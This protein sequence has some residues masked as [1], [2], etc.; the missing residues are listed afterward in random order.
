MTLTRLDQFALGYHVPDGLGHYALA[1]R[2]WLRG[3]G[4]ASDLYAERSN[5]PAGAWR[6]YRTW[7][8]DPG[9][10][11]LLHFTTG[12]AV[13]ESVAGL[14]AA[15]LLYY[16][17]ITPAHFFA[18]IMPREESEA[19]QGRDQLA[20]LAPRFDACWTHSSYS[21]AEVRTAGARKV[22]VVPL[23][24]DFAALDLPP[25]P[26][27][28]A[29]LANFPG[30]TILAVSR[31]APN[32]GDEELLAVTAELVH[33]LRRRIRVVRVGPGDAGWRRELERRAAAA[34]LE[35]EITF[36]GALRQTEANACWRAADVYLCLSEHEG[37]GMPLVEAMHFNLPIVALDRAAV[38]GTLAGGGVLVRDCDP[39]L[40]ARTVLRVAD[41]RALRAAM[42]ARQQAAL[43]NYQP[44]AVL[45][46]MRD[47]LADLPPA[48]QAAFG[49]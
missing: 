33:A 38:G 43:A 11:V 29:R 8:A 5:L 10:A 17:N 13:N 23:L 31:V 18:G 27:W 22:R 47:A 25:D 39:A 2:E 28:T 32:K 1:L 4:L 26:A 48:G 49:R 24:R 46:A 14:P 45:A 21:A 35:H 12:C 37:F 44:A 15:R 16:H 3:Q 20:A 40:L 7:Q 36:T 42:L 6:D 9:A 19:R 41:D 34:G 30:I